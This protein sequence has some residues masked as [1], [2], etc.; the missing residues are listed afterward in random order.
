LKADVLWRRQSLDEFGHL[1]LI[2]KLALGHVDLRLTV[3]E[4][5]LHATIDLLAI[6]RVEDVANGLALGEGVVVDE[7]VLRVVWVGQANKELTARKSV[8]VLGSVSFDPL[9]VPDLRVLALSV[10]LGDDL[11]ETAVGVHVLPERLAVLG[12]VATT[13]VLLSTV[14]DE[15]D[16][17]TGQG[18]HDSVVELSVGATMVVKET[19]VIVIVN[20]KTEGIDIGEVGFLSI[21][22]LLDL[23]HVLTATKD[24]VDGVVHRVV[25]EPSDGTLV[26]SDVSGV[27]V[28]ALSHLEDAG[29]LTKLRPEVLGNLGDGVNSQTIEAVGLNQIVNPVLEFTSDVGVWLIKIGQVSETT[30]FNLALVVPVVDLAVTVVVVWLVEGGD[31]SKII[32]DR[33]D[34]VTDNIDHN[35]D[36]FLM[37]SGNQLLEVVL[38]AEVAVDLVPVTGPVSVVATIAVVNGRWDPNSVEAHT[39]DVVQLTFEALESATAVVGKVCAGVSWAI[40]AGETIGEDLVNG[41]LFP[42]SCVSSESATSKSGKSEWFVH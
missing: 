25:E 12:V 42:C 40:S 3:V 32:T 28:E 16:T 10:D 31:L 34:V 6:V 1:Y 35:P 18:E 23:S 22:S 21:V 36:T 26:G 41:A 11:V 30:V 15:W 8:E 37:G 20:E 9:L 39:L 24:V 27:T 14:V 29:G 19:G 4:L 38:C 17:T 5:N 33:G 2:G 7:E 13:V